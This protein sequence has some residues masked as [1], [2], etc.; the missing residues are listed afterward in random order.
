MQ[1]GGEEAGCNHVRSVCLLGHIKKPSLQFQTGVNTVNTGMSIFKNHT[2]NERS[3]KWEIIRGMS[4][5]KQGG[6]HWNKESRKKDEHK[7]RQKTSPQDTAEECAFS[8]R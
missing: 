6:K 8:C 2:N 3:G 7:V 1:C 4:W 5:E